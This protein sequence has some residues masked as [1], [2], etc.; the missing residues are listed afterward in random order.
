M[1]KIFF[2]SA[3]GAGKGI[4]GVCRGERFALN[5]GEM[6]I[7]TFTSCRMGHK[8][9]PQGIKQRKSDAPTVDY[10]PPPKHL[11]S[12]CLAIS[13]RIYLTNV[14]YE[15]RCFNCIRQMFDIVREQGE[16]ESKDER[17]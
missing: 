7:D 9:I 10:T 1:G 4:A 5:V 11:C 8:L 14:W 13:E 2:N 16:H 3:L 12:I 15:N 17:S 6:A